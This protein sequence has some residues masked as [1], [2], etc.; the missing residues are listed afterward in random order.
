MVIGITKPLRF[1]IADGAA[2]VPCLHGA[3]I[4]ASAGQA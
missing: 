2:T 1:F 4:L 3:P